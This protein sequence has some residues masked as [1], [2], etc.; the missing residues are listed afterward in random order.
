MKLS[1]RDFIRIDT[2]RRERDLAGL[3]RRRSQA[4]MQFQPE[5]HLIPQTAMLWSHCDSL[6]SATMVA[7]FLCLLDQQWRLTESTS[8]SFCLLAVQVLWVGAS[9]QSSY[10]LYPTPIWPFYPRPFVP[11]L[12]IFLLPGP[13]QLTSP[14]LPLVTLC[15]F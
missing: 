13:D 5:T 8:E 7:W 11:D 12:P 6:C 1:C 3:D 4:L 2:Y 10:L 14:L 15:I 9:M